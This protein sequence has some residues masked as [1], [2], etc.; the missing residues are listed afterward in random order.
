MGDRTAAEPLWNHLREFAA[1]GT[2]D[3]T[4]LCVFLEQTGYVAA[5]GPFFASAALC[6]PLLA[7]IDHPALESVVAGKTTGTVAVAGTSGEWA[8]NA[9]PVKFF[10]ARRRSRRLHRGRGTRSVGA[11]RSRH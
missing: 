6:A 2:G 11:R 3:A 4:D 8:P 7:A 5:P 10:V 1:L 9:E